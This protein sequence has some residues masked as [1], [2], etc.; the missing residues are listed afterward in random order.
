MAIQSF[1]VSSGVSQSEFD[2]HTH[3][4]AKVTQFGVDSNKNYG[5]VTRIDIVDDSEVNGTDGT[6]LESIGITSST[7]ATGTPN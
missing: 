3:N 5:S 7:T 1:Q 6:D 2:T 4:Y